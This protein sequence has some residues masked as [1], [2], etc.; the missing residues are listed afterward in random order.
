M[1]YQNKV[2]EIFTTITKFYKKPQK[3]FTLITFYYKV[4]IKKPD[5]NQVLF[6]KTLC[7]HYTRKRS[8]NPRLD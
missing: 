2:I 6:L 4:L 5:V 7:L 1:I 3:R 8:P